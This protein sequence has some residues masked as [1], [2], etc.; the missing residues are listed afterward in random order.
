MQRGYQFFAFIAWDC[1]TANEPT[2]ATA[3]YMRVATGRI[4]A[5]DSPLK[6]LGAKQRRLKKKRRSRKA[7]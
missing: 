6:R 1:C 4:A 3:R 7:A 2:P 5:I